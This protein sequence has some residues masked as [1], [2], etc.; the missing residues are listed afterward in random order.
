MADLEHFKV[1]FDPAFT[2]AYNVRNNRYR[3]FRWTPRTA[4]I[5]TMFVVVVPSIFTAMAYSTDGKWD[6][7]AKRRGDDMREY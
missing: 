5:T 2:K 4:F 1:K 3:Y 6:F 7:R